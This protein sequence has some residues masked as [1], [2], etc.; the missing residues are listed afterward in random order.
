MQILPR[1]LLAIAL[2]AAA[3]LVHARALDL[4]FTNWDDDDYVIR[5]AGIERLDAARVREMFRPTSVVVGNWAP[6]T[7]LSLAVDYA[8]W[9]RRPFGYH[10]TNLLLHAIAVV[11]LFLLL[12]RIL[13]RGNPGTSPA[14]AAIAAAL[15]AIH[16]VQ[17][18]SVAWVAERKNVLGMSLF[19]AA[20]LAWLRAAGSRWR[21]G[22]YAAF[23]LL[24]AAALLAKAQAVIL[25]PLLLLYEWIE[26]P[27]PRP[28]A[29]RC[30]AL[31]LPAFALAVGVG[32]VT[33]AAQQS[34]AQMRPT[35]DFAGSVATAPTLVLGYVKDLL[36]PMS[37]AA[38]LQRPIYRTPG[39]PVPVA[40]WLVIIAW[41]AAVLAG[42]RE[43][44]HRA[45][46]SLWFLG[47]LAPV[48]NFVPLGVLAADRY[49]YWASPG[50][51]AL[52]GLWTSRAWTRLKSWRRGFL[53]ALGTAVLVMLAALTV[54]RVEVWKDAV[55]LWSDAV[56]KAP[57]DPVV[58]TNLSSALIVA[59]RSGEA[60]AHLRHALLREPRSFRLRINLGVA[61]LN[62]GRVEE[63]ILEG[64]AATG[65]N[66]KLPEAWLLYGTALEMRGRRAEAIDAFRR[67]TELRPGDPAATIH[68]RALG[69]ELARP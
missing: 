8:L 2:F 37:R 47:A 33:I 50:L 54:A 16:P 69:V 38:I 39:A 29:Q 65:L 22:A 68:L 57:E 60:I 30:A 52:A 61:L 40:T 43:R 21:P 35:H 27:P 19:L 14:P 53:A 9:E 26:R 51:F 66:P 6:V 34:G 58:R 62:L 5:N 44:P 10:L 15:F 48:L 18:E 23:L 59:G 31:L 12:D 46:F 64:R 1:T 41:V 63:A 11:L 45:F 32:L 67:V 42:R 25:P 24:Y 55:T 36:L 28:S 7:I 20:F 3:A 4:G 56:R 49:Q 17:V 13:A